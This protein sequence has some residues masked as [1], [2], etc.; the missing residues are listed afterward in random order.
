MLRARLTVGKVDVK[1]GE[2]G[3]LPLDDHRA[4]WQARAGKSGIRMHNITWQR[5]GGYTKLPALI[6]Q[7]GADPATV[8]ASAGLPREI[9]DSGEARMPYSGLGRLLLGASTQTGHKHLAL[10]A[11]RM[12]ELA[13]LGLV[14]QAAK[15]CKTVG[16]SLRLLTAYQHL[17]GNGGE[18][19]V[20]KRN[21]IV[22]LGYAI[23]DPSATN[24]DQ[25]N[26]AA[27]AGA[28]SFMRE[29]CGNVFIPTA[30]YLP[31]VEPEDRIYYRRTFKACPHFEAQYC[32]MRF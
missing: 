16:E 27:L 19:F 8:L 10:L 7:L 29:L 4:T 22:N 26:D 24:K 28:F 1:K 12:W 20:N 32:A 31:Q 5:V 21:S 14:G 2:D 17:A 13:D 25:I 9:L 23:R 18:V 11:G 15:N 3:D 30:V 6:G